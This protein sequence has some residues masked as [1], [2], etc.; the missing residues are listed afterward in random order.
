MQHIKKSFSSL[1][2][3]SFSVRR[4]IESSRAGQTKKT[5]LSLSLHLVWSISGQS[6]EM[7]KREKSGALKS[8]SRLSESGIDFYNVARLSSRWRTFSL[9]L[10]RFG[11]IRRDETEKMRGRKRKKEGKKKQDQDGRGLA[12]IER[13]LQPLCTTDMFKPLELRVPQL[14]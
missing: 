4:S 11:P 5:F 12:R 10:S 9:P 8:S 1:F 3:S 6:V 7:A 13:V 2:F 14:C